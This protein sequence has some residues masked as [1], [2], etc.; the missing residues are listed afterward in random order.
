MLIYIAHHHRKTA[1]VLDTLVLSE[2]ECF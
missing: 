1:T 2:Q